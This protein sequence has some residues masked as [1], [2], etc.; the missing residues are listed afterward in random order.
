MAIAAEVIAGILIAVLL[1]A[2]ALGLFVGVMGAVLSEG[3]ERC[4]RCGHWTLDVHG[5]AHPHGCPTTRYEQ[6][7][8]VVQAAFHRAHVLHGRRLRH[9]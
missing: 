2:T 4:G 7:A 5:K 3:F 1:A 8:H 6:G 9:H